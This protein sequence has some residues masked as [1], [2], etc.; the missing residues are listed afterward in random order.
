MGLFV[1]NR[2]LLRKLTTIH[3]KLDILMA[4]QTEL[5]AELAAKTAQIRK[6]IGEI[7][8]KLDAL[9]EQINNAQVSPELRAAADA[10]GTA[11]QA[12]DDIVPDAPPPA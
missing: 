5:A 4:S 8:S 3:L 10:L 1:S 9:L 6:T 11:V 12:A 7:T 2:D